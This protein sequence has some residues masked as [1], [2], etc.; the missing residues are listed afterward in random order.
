MENPGQRVFDLSEA[1]VHLEDG[2]G[3]ESMELTP[4]FWQELMSGERAVSGWLVG[5]THMA[6]DA[7][8]WEMH[9]RGKELLYLLSGAIDLVL[10]LE[11]G[12]RIV[13]LRAGGACLVP[14]GVWHRQIVVE[15]G[16]LVFMTYGTGTEHRP[17]EPDAA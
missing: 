14:R 2:G 8:N 16:D 12:E 10:E 3:A 5:R 11:V 6:A 9:P 7:P 15:P 13:A 1:L 4:S 17:V